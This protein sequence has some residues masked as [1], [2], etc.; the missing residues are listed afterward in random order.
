MDRDDLTIG[1]LVLGQEQDFISGTGT[2]MSKYV[3]TDL[4]EDINKTYAYL[5][6]KHISGE[7]DSLGREKPFFNVVV[8]AR[9]IRYRGTDIDRG[10]IRV[11]AKKASDVTTSYLAN[12]LLQDWMVKERFGVFLNTWGLE[13][14]SFN[15]VV[16]KFVEKDEKL[17]PSV[18]PWS[19]LICD[20]VDFYNNPVIET[21]EV[22]EAQL[23]ERGYNKDAVK[24][25]INTSRTREITNKQKVDNR[26]GFYKLYEV[27]GNFP[28]SRITGKDSDDDIY[29]PQMHVLS[30]SYNKKTKKWEEFTLYAGKEKRSPYLLTSLMP[31]ADGSITLNGTVKQLFE[32]QWMLNHTKKQIKDQ[33]DLASKLIFQ[34]SDGNFVGQNALNAI[35]SGD[36]LIHSLNQPLT[37]VANNSHDVTALQSFGNDWKAL[38]NEIAGISE[39]MLGNTAPSGTAWRQVEAILQENHSLLELMTENKGLAIEEMLREFVLPFIKKKMD[40]SDE[41]ATTLGAYGIDKL[42]KIY[43]HSKAVE[44]F[45]KKVR[46]SILTKGEV[47]QFDLNQEIQAIQTTRAESGPQRFLKPS[48]VSDLTWK[49]VLKDFEWDI[50]VDVTGEQ[51]NDRADMATLT[52]MFQTMMGLNGQPMSPESKLI[53]NKLL[54]RTN[55]VSPIE[56]A[57]LESQ[58]PIQPQDPVVGAGEEALQVKQ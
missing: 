56:L 34:T 51:A 42:E 54:M 43:V 8:A 11:K 50:E 32:A 13:L 37:Q 49:E 3:T 41:I 7:T 27:H 24:D 5:E 10:N 40:T 18:V 44:E 9:N 48:D 46:D 53:F 29:A 20:S 33:L 1:Q 47:P 52:T 45:N 39:S 58:P 12:A 14:A 31:S 22:S 17:I 6:S 35:E 38:S 25:L 26:T 21:M 55:A 4:Y 19:R 2:L 57:S 23:Y 15:D 30:F 36:I 16:V 28:L